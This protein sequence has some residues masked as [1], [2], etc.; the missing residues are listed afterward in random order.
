MKDLKR[1]LISRID[2]IGDVVLTLPLA[3]VLKRKY[4]DAEILFL[5]QEYTRPVI[6][7][8]PGVDRFIDKKSIQSGGDFKK[9]NVDAILHVYPEKSIASFAK[10]AG[11]PIRIG[12]S[13]RIYHWWTCN[14]RLNLG[15]KN[16]EQHEAQLNLKL[17]VPLGISENISLSE[18]TG[19]DIFRK[20]EVSE[21]IRSMI[22]TGK[23][24][25]ILHPTSK[26]SAREWGLENF[27]A[28]LKMLPPEKF[29]LFL[30]GTVAD[31]KLLVDW[32]NQHP[33][34]KNMCGQLS[35]DELMDLISVSDALVAASTGPLHLAAAYGIHAIGIYA[36]IRPMHIGRWGPVGRKAKAFSLLKNCSD[37]RQ[38][39]DCHCIR[40]VPPSQ[41]AHYLEA[42]KK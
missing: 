16:S 10:S 38:T 11:I 6:K 1:I 39:G 14:K 8:C 25:V 34:I 22:D 13:H 31:G 32:S 29:N 17:G 28:L 7:R 35:L 37:C 33:G 19:W 21:R 30:S 27:S 40:E 3:I 26:G 41:I 15:R 2:S 4:P 36:P 5:G 42:I 20:K 18:I 24:N 12:T 23:K 9:L